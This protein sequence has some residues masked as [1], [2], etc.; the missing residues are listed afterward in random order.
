LQY[1]HKAVEITNELLVKNPNDPTLCA[2]LDSTL[3]QLA[4]AQIPMISLSKD[5]I[6]TTRAQYEKYLRHLEAKPKLMIENPIHTV[7]FASL[8]YY[9]I[10]QALEDRIIRTQLAN[11]YQ[12]GSYI[13]NYVAPHVTAGRHLQYQFNGSSS[14]FQ[15]YQRMERRLRVG[16]LSAFMYHHSVG[17]LTENVI[18]S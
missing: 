17:L 3:L 5:H 4:N 10:Y 11:I 9:A 7:S 8:G 6:R 12:K 1:L 2:T 18:A 16:F 14:Q 15:G 13:L